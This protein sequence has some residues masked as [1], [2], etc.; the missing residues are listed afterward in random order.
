[1]T[2]HASKGLEFPI[3]FVVNLAKGASGFPKPVRVSGDE[4]SV[5][6]FVSDSDDEE[7]FREREETKR[8]MYVALTR[9]RDRLYVG[10]VLK[11]GEFA[12]GRGSLGEVLPATF[13]G[14]FERAAQ[15]PGE[16]IEWTAQSGRA[17]R[18]QVCRGLPP[19]K[20][21]VLRPGRL[22]E[23]RRQRQ[24]C[25]FLRTAD[26]F[27]GDR[28]RAGDR[29]LRHVV[30][31]SVGRTK[32]AGRSARRHAGPSPVPVRGGDRRG[33]RAR[34]PAGPSRGARHGRRRRGQ[35]RP[36][37]RRLDGDASRPEVARLLSS[38]ERIHELPFSYVAPG[39]PGRVLRGTIDCLVR[40]PDGSIVVIEFKTGA[41]S[42]AHTAQLDLY[43]GA[44][45]DIFPGA[46]VSG[47]V[48]YPR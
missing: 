4:V 18:F 40:Q 14:L 26:R 33:G 11:D 12:I 21:P 7:R 47:V 41:P 17:Y 8:L 44:A 27:R 42:P 38:G 6:P 28:A 45:R 22:R 35:R 25:G 48:V 15:D 29:R 24:A 32:G 36:R 1:M 20:S 30:A 2:V 39:Q 37:H 31:P 9:A 34:G 16:S 19:L 46:P 3:V 23:R 13:R 43:V 5:G 10:T